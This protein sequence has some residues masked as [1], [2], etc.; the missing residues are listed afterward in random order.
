MHTRQVDLPVYALQTDL[1]HGHV[2]RGARRFI[3]RSR[4]TRAESTLVNAD[5]EESHLDPI[6]ADP[7]HNRFFKTLVP[8]LRHKV[9]VGTGPGPASGP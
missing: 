9:F 8:F 7:G 6:M 1:T 4:T 3:Q 2:L 5:P